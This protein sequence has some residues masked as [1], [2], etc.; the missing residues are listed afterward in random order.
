[1]IDPLL[2]SLFVLALEKRW[3]LRA[4]EVDTQQK[5]EIADT[6][7]ALPSSGKHNDARII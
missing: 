7:F 2:T 6:E 3:L 1:M 5:W 4:V